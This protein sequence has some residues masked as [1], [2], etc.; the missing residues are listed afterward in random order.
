MAEG[1]I[2]QIK[3]YQEPLEKATEALDWKLVEGTKDEGTLQ[4]LVNHLDKAVESYAS[5]VRPIKALF[6]T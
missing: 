6:V 3:L 1:Y 5:A 2:S 4:P